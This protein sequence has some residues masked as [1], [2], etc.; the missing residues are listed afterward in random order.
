MTNWFCSA[1]ARTL[2]AGDVVEIIPMTSG[3]INHEEHEG[4]DLKGRTF[5]ASLLHGS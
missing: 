3:A 5:T 4:Q 1:R 2:R